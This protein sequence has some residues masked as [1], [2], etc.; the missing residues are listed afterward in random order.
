MD[1]TT[2]P[3]PAPRFPDLVP[4]SSADSEAPVATATTRRPTDPDAAT[5]ATADQHPGSGRGRRILATI[6]WW[7]HGLLRVYLALMMLVYGASKTSLG[8]FGL[9]DMGDALVSFGEMSPMG[10]LWRMVAYSPLFQI[11]AGVAEV[12]AGLAL[13]WRRTAMLGALIAIADMALVLVLNLGYD[14][15]VKQLSA[16][17]LGV[18]MIVLIPWLPRL[19][20]TFLG[21]DA[22]PAARVP[23]LLPSRRIDRVA[24]ALAAGLAVL[25]AAGAVTYSVLAL[26]AQT[27]QDESAPAGVWRVA[28]DT[29]APTDQVADDHRWQAI[30]FGTHE[31]PGGVSRVQLR[32]VDG[33]LWS[34]TYQRTGGDSAEGKQQVRLE[35]R[36]LRQQGTTSEEQREQRPRTLTL[37][38][39]AQ[40]DGGLHVRGKDVDLRLAPDDQ[41]RV[42][43]DRGFRWSPR[44]DDPFN[45]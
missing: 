6:L 45:R 42:L 36:T 11:L 1:P 9:T 35:L 29:A 38:V 13:L 39:S 10:M 32:L 20:R 15:P 19:L 33:T 12:G 8:Q 37:E 31:Y 16:V 18:G 17:L 27:A 40:A 24:S 43:F 5:T 3:A 21:H 4:S 34:G 30:A 22:V 25:A 23:T 28:S 41:A 26:P 7:G 44:A 2:P 14:V